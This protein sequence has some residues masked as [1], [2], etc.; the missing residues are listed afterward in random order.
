VA[1]ARPWQ[2]R[3][4]SKADL[5]AEVVRGISQREVDVVSEI[6]D[7]DGT[8]SERLTAAVRAFASRA[9]RAELH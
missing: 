8:A 2:R 6:A 5:F 3:S 7:S 9:I 1:A 4:S